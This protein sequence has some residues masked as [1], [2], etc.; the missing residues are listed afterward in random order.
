MQS[1]FVLMLLQLI[2]NMT[3]LVVLKL[4]LPLQKFAPIFVL[5]ALVVAYGMTHF[6]ISQI[7]Q[8]YIQFDYHLMYFTAP[9]FLVAQGMSP[10]G[11]NYAM[12]ILFIL[13]IGGWRF[14]FSCDDADYG[15]EKSVNLFKQI[16]VLFFKKMVTDCKGNEIT[17]AK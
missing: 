11:V 6:D 1:L 5:L 3:Y 17:G 4:K 2:Y 12:L 14:S 9:F 16:A 7:Q 10:E 15:R 13:F 8:S